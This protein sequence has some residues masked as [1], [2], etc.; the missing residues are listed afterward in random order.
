M[1][2]AKKIY[3][4]VQTREVKGREDMETGTTEEVP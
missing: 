3:F 2:F 4:N 1:K